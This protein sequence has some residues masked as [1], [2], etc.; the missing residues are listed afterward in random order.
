MGQPLPV[1]LDYFTI[2]SSYFAVWQLAWVESRLSLRPVLISI[3]TLIV[4]DRL[5]DGVHPPPRKPVFQ[6]FDILVDKVATGEKQPHPGELSHLSAQ[7]A[8]L[9]HLIHVRRA[10]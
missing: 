1:T 10:T 2:H 3:H 4:Q 9:V 5:P 7:R 6:P 8:L